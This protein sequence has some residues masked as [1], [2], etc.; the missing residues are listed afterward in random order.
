[1]SITNFK[2]KFKI[3]VFFSGE[4]WNSK[5]SI[6]FASEGLYGEKGPR[7]GGWLYGLDI[8]WWDRDENG[9]DDDADYPLLTRKI[10]WMLKAAGEVEHVVHRNK[11]KT[12]MAEVREISVSKGKERDKLMA[13]VREISVSKGKERDNESEEKESGSDSKKNGGYGS[14]RSDGDAATDAK[15]SDSVRDGV[16]D[17]LGFVPYVRY[18]PKSGDAVLVVADAEYKKKESDAAPSYTVDLHN[19]IERLMALI[20]A[21]S[22]SGLTASANDKLNSSVANFS[23]VFKLKKCLYCPDGASVEFGNDDKTSN[24]LRISGMREGVAVAMTLEKAAS[25]DDSSREKELE[26]ELIF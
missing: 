1:L 2:F 13:E 11:C 5:A 23:K 20:P 26:S 25:E 7:T 22:G 6:D 12:L 8:N 3:Q 10:S 18:D 9:S 19:A 21:Q 24:V 17:T 4:E 16:T 14:N 15:S